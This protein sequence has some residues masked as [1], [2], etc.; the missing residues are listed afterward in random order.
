M[1]LRYNFASIQ[2]DAESRWGDLTG[3]Q[4]TASLFREL[5]FIHW[6]EENIGDMF[7]PVQGEMIHGYG[8]YI[9]AEFGPKA[10]ET[11]HCVYID[12]DKLTA[13]QLTEFL[14]RFG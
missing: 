5:E 6:I 9:D 4:M 11:L 1:R 2:Q 14:L 13:I 8:W 12:D 7:E 10:G 3:R